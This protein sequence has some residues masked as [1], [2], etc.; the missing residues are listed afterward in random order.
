MD[1]DTFESYVRAANRA[2]RRIKKARGKIRCSYLDVL[3]DLTSWASV[4]FT[5]LDGED[6]T[7]VIVE[8]MRRAYPNA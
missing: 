7:D 2:I 8:A 4:N 3:C 1:C 5:S 6:T